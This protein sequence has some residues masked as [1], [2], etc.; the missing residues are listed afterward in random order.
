MMHLHENVRSIALLSNKERIRYIQDVKWIGYKR[1]KEI[2]KKMD[3]L[4]EYPKIDRM[5]NALVTSETNNGKSVLARK[6]CSLHK[7]YFVD[8]GN[9][10]IAPVI[11]MEAP[12]SPEEKRFYNVLL[13]E[14]NIP[15]RINDLVDKK[16]HLAFAMLKR[17]E[18][19]MLIIDEFHNI[20]AGSLAKQRSFLNVIRNMAN[21]LKI[22]IIAFGITEAANVINVDPQLSNRFDREKL[23]LW[24]KDA[25]YLKLL[26]SFESII[27]L[28]NPSNLIQDEIAVKILTKSEKTI[29]EISKIIR[30]ASIEAIES[31]TEAITSQILD[32]IKYVQPS[33]R[34]RQ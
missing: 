24:K 2:L 11:Y 17:L 14:L 22:V 32:K 3:D 18:T 29:G 16:Q 21:E 19:K 4:L 25:E 15:F 30:L 23:P 33:L 6:Y 26:A 12:P 31:G 9:R 28:K 8:N 27:P 1:A 7:P 34:K 13:K 10:L 20:L 5:P